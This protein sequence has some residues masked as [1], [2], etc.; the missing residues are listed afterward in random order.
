M[1]HS[2]NKNV[3]ALGVIKADSNLDI[4]RYKVFS[5]PVDRKYSMSPSATCSLDSDT[6]IIGGRTQNSGGTYLAYIYAF[7]N[8]DIDPLWGHGLEDLAGNWSVRDLTC[9]GSQIYGVLSQ[10]ETFTYEY[11]SDQCSFFSFDA[12]NRNSVTTATFQDEDRETCILFQ[13]PGTNFLWLVAT[14]AEFHLSSTNQ[15]RDILLLKVSKTIFELQEA[16]WVDL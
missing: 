4:E 9:E 15:S 5:E 8:T 10:F 2:T 6:L 3:A 14:V 7:T 13:E 12:N 16:L 1:V 11:R